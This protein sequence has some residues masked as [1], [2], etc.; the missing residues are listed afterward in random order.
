[1]VELHQFEETCSSK[2]GNKTTSSTK[3]GEEHFSK[4]SLLARTWACRRSLSHWPGYHHTVLKKKQLSYVF[5]NNPYS[6]HGILKAVFF[7]N[8]VPV[9][10]FLLFVCLLVFHHFTID[11]VIPPQWGETVVPL[12]STSKALSFCWRS[13]SRC[14]APKFPQRYHQ[15]WLLDHI[16]HQRHSPQYSWQY[17]FGGA[18]VCQCLILLRLVTTKESC[19]Q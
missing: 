6:S 8:M 1:M 10:I 12:W 2:F 5:K 9:R 18:E 3:L 17:F 11:H 19:T 4:F 13:P 14:W 16:H 7:L 15:R